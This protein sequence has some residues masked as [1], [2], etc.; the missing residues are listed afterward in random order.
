ML[1]A[2]GMMAAANAQQQVLRQTAGV[3][4]SHALDTITNAETDYL[5]G[6][7]PA[8]QVST[9]AIQLI[10]STISGTPNGV[11]TIEFSA[12]GVN[13]DPIDANDT[14]H[15]GA[16]SNNIW[17]YTGKAVYYVRIKAVGRG[18][19]AIKIN[20]FVIYRKE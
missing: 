13:Y 8:G 14:F 16:A 9:F 7:L 4:S 6:V 10:H 5:Y 3:S 18:T 15:I 11:A 19:A 17:Y 12:D 1:F 2:F 20:G